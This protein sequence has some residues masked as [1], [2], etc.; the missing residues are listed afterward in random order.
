MSFCALL[1]FPTHNPVQESSVTQKHAEAWQDKERKASS[2]AA[3]KKGDAGEIHGPEES[4][5][6]RNIPRVS[7]RPVSPS[8]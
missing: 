8:C 3:T 4:K 5:Q 7:S 2:R 6:R 1:V